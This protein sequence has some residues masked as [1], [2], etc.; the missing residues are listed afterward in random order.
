[1]KVLRLTVI[2]LMMILVG[3][4]FTACSSK[5]M[6]DQK[7]TMGYKLQARYYP[8]D[9]PVIKK[10][11]NHTYPEAFDNDGKRH[12]WKALGGDS[13][14]KILSDTTTEC[15]KKEKCID[16]STVNYIMTESPCIWPYKN[17]YAVVG[18]CWN[19]TNRGLFYTG[20][21]VHKIKFY[22]IIE[23]MY[24]TYGLD[25]NTPCWHNLHPFKC[26]EARKKYA[27]S[28]CLKSVKENEPWESTASPLK[29]LQV[30]DPRIELYYRYAQKV[31]ASDLKATP[32][33]EQEYLEQLFELNIRER[34]GS[35]SD[36]KKKQLMDID[37][38][39]REQRMVV[40]TK[41]KKN[42]ESF[43][44]E[45]YMNELNIQINNELDAYADV[46]SDDEYFKLFGA[47]KGERFDI[48]DSQ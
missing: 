12:A 41:E 37:K 46:L 35:I 3:L 7:K 16:I 48:R 36:E 31:E 42:L 29:D 4:M 11:A 24:G 30:P 15:A 45:A 44:H 19:A 17:Y 34:L 14:G 28:K 18:V 6:L 8:I 10:I 40:S 43:D 2:V 38:K 26:K 9:N 33:I 22:P 23:K 27:W 21:T 20:K 5:N 25:Y 1:M 47:K 13:G 39:F 32:N